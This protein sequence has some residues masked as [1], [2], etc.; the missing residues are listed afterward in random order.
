MF[1]NIVLSHVLLSATWEA[2]GFIFVLLTSRFP[3]MTRGQHLPESTDPTK[4]SI[5]R[6]SS[7]SG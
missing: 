1:V 2:D 6:T 3:S 5:N 7:F 4:K